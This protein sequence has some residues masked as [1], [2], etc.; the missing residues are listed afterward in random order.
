MISEHSLQCSIVFSGF[1]DWHKQKPPPN[2][3]ALPKGKIFVI[4]KEPI[5][6]EHAL[7]LL[8]PD[9]NICC[10]C[11]FSRV[12]T[13]LLSQHLKQLLSAA[14]GCGRA[15][16]RTEKG[17]LL[18]FHGLSKLATCFEDVFSF[19]WEGI[20]Q[21]GEKLDFKKESYKRRM[22]GKR[23]RTWVL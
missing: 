2:C 17:R 11:C 15:R 14:P 4:S 12:T 21:G 7:S 16:P 22:V 6:T 3:S 13:S 20:K 5:F 18:D 8:I 19:N 1:P 23:K 10:M 9:I